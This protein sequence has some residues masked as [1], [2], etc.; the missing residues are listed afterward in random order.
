MPQ[1]CIVNDAAQSQ[2]S[3]ASQAFFLATEWAIANSSAVAFDCEGVN[4]SRVGSL[5]LVSLCFEHDSS[6]VYLVDT[7]GSC[8]IT[9]RQLRLQA[10]KRLFESKHVMKIIHDCRM[11][12]D[13]LWHHFGIK[14]ER[15]HDTSCWHFAVSGRW[16]A[17]LNETLERMDFGPTPSGTV[18]FTKGI[19]SSGPQGH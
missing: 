3:S 6:K 7:G 9:F 15:V 1:V 17:G 16:K 5:E 2:M 14:L 10:L 4:L 18:P 13:A 12:S 19:Q 8:D 11:D